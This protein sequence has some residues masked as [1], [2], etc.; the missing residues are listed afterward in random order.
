MSEQEN[1]WRTA[2]GLSQR[3]HISIV[4]PDQVEQLLINRADFFDYVLIA[5]NNETTLP[6]IDA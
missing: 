6:K 1:I 3:R 2:G 5:R 4:N